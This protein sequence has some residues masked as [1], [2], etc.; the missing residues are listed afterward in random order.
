M[1]TQTVDYALRATVCLAAAHPRPQTRTQL[2]EL[3][4]A[5]SAYLAKIM[6]S[7]ARAGL[8]HTQRGLHGGFT[9][10]RK[11][12]EIALLDVVNAVEPIQR[13]TTCPLKLSS[14]V[15]QLCPLH[16]RLDLAL[17]HLE[18]AFAGVT[19]A[20]IVN[21]KSGSVPLCES[22]GDALVS[23]EPLSSSPRVAAVARG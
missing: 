14:H 13:I 16:H 22:P 11:P 17:A 23:L 20:D 21:E 6:T 12:T 15:G 3:T 4:K 8:V 10:L 19:L 9:L 18:G 7:L 1:L 2:V 5:P